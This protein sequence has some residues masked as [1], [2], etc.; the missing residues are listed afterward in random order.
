MPKSR[1]AIAAALAAVALVAAAAT[2]IA[3]SQRFPDVP[4]DHY[5]YEAVEWAAEVGVTLGYTDGTFKPEEALIKRH[6]VVFMER[7]YD[8]ILQAEE[9]EDFT[10]G[11]M[12]VLL[13]A[14]N[15]GTIRDDDTT[16]D[17]SNVATLTVM[18]VAVGAYHSC[19]VRANS[20]I[21]CWGRNDR[22]Q[23]NTPSGQF[24]AVSAAGDQ[25]CGL[26]TDGTIGCWGDQGGSDRRL[27]AP[28]CDN[29][30]RCPGR[31]ALGVSGSG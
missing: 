14:I 25:S 23:I 26:Q 13:K 5:A 20:T 29:L 16:S 11:D 30:I 17:G 7:Y 8:E 28:S 2:A 3:Q 9:S 19:V 18:R 10:R 1:L 15:D 6:A 27:D 4:P 12:M 21:T 22:G 24:S 31:E